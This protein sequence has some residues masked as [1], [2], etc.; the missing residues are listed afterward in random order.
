MT[1]NYKKCDVN[2]FFEILQAIFLCE[3]K[4]NDQNNF[5]DSNL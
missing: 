2:H 4:K 5:F 1:F 3:I